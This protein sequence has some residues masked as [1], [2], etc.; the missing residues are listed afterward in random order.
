MTRR[1]SLLGEMALFL[2]AVFGPAAAEPQTAPAWQNSLKPAGTPAQELVFLD[3]G[4]PL[5]QILLS[6]EPSPPEKNAALELA[7]WLEAMSSAPVTMTVLRETERSDPSIPYI[8]IGQTELL[9]KASLPDAEQPLAADGYGLA[10]KDGNLYLWGGRSRGILNAVFA[11]LEEDMGCRWYSN[12]S[13]QIPK[14]PRISVRPVP[15]T[16]NPPFA[17]RDPFYFVSFNAD[18]SLRNRTNAPGAAVSEEFG[19]RIDYAGYFVH[20]LCNVFL[21]RDTYFKDHPEYYM[22]DKDGK[23]SSHQPCTT[24]PDVIRIVSDEVLDAIRKNPAMEIISVSKDDGGEECLCQRCKALAEAEG[25]HMAPL[26]VLVNAVAEAVEQ[27]FPAVTVDTLAYVETVRPPKTLRPRKNV[28]IRMCND[29]VGSWKKPFT[30][31]RDCEFGKIVQDW[32]AIHD[33][34]YIW[35]YVTN[36]SHYMAPMPNLDAVADNIRF[37]ADNQVQGVMTQAGYTS[38]GVE[39]EWMR[40]WIFAKLMWNPSWDLESLQKD[41]IYG[42]FGRASELIWQ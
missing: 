30:P 20:T 2:C 26:L 28:A 34:L 19:G 38:T 37:Y 36:F 35:D 24:H 42:N 33:N 15:R 21:K 31:A 25:S 10:V 11:L 14:T 27:E 1:T 23:R 22:L 9:K 7:R 12:E 29:F 6:R 5:F 40:S 41:F 8:S 4:K 13:I 39:R 3:E 32:S 16:Y 18:W 17:L